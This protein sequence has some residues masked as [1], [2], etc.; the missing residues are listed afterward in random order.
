LAAATASA[1]AAGAPGDVLTQRYDN[2]RNGRAVDDTISPA[3]VSDGKWQKLAKLN[4]SGA[5]YAQPLF[6]KGQRMADGS[7]HDLL[8]VVTAKNWVYGFDA[9]TYQSLWTPRQLGEPDKSYAAL[10]TA[11]SGDPKWEC[12][13]MSPLSASP[14]L[15]PAEYG[16]GNQ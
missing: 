13:Q 4:V 2:G 1:N 10:A 9:N 6:V 7:T 11:Q 14:A 15:P 8:V 12:A 3:T 16:I 5:V